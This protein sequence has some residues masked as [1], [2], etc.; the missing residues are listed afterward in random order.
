MI[1]QLSQTYI[2]RH[3]SSGHKDDVDIDQFKFIEDAIPA[4]WSEKNSV[5]TN[6]WI[7]LRP[8]AYSLNQSTLIFRVRL[9]V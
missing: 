6:I 1:L 8:F 9:I 2:S 5:E 4:F 3:L 7:R